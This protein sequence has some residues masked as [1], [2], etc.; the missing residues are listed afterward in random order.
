MKIGSDSVKIHVSRRRAQILGAFAASARFRSTS[1][2]SIY[3][4]PTRA[5]E[6][7]F[8]ESPLRR[9]VKDMAEEMDPRACARLRRCVLPGAEHPLVRAEQLLARVLPSGSGSSVG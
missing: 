5:V 2:W 4:G 1:G 3:L 6:R 8:A 7:R 9:P